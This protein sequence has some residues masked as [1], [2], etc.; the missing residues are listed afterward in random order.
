MTKQTY[1][2]SCHCGRVQFE[3]DTILDH[4]RKC[5]CSICLKRGALIHRVA[6][7]DFRPLTPVEDLKLYIWG[8]RTAKDYF[9]PDCGIL[10]YRRPSAPSE[11][12]KAD[13]MEAFDGWSINA[14]CLDTDLSR[15]EVKPI[16]GAAI[17]YP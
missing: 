9:C 12:E 1:K 7:Q 17:S 2:G 11:S 4:V 8:T 10:P 5:N 15:L 3:V 13:G 14:R 16:D 6:E